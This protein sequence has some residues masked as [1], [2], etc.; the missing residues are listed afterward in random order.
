M[1]LRPKRRQVTIGSSVTT[2]AFGNSDCPRTL[3]VKI[4]NRFRVNQRGLSIAEDQQQ[5]QQQCELVLILRRE[6][7]KTMMAGIANKQVSEVLP[8]DAR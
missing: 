1:S 6:D 5:R 4:K 2:T 8:E 3:K 7:P